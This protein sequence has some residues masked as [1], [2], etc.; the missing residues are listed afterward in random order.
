MKPTLILAMMFL[1][2]LAAYEPTERSAAAST[3]CLHRTCDPFDNCTC[4]DGPGD[5]GG[6]G[7]PV[8]TGGPCGCGEDVQPTCVACRGKLN[9][10]T[11]N[12]Q[13]VCSSSGNGCVQSYDVNNVLSCNQLFGDPCSVCGLGA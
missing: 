2:V 12:T 1:G 10:T 4:D 11:C 3:D 7:N 6:G 5:P 9:K 13:R 8:N